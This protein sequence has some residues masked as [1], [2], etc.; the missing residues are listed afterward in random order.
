MSPQGLNKCETIIEG[1]CSLM[2][3]YQVKA[4]D[5]IFEFTTF[6]ILDFSRNNFYS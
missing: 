6:A 5:E 2:I 1:N 4:T 3:R